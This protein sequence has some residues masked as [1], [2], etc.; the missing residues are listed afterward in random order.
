MDGGDRPRR[1]HWK[2]ER[3]PRATERLDRLPPDEQANVKAALRV[4][5]VRHGTWVVL[6]RMLKL[7][8]K[9]LERMLGRKGKPVPGLAIRLARLAGCSVE[10][11]LSGAFAR[12]AVCPTCGHTVGAQA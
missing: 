5:R 6:G 12:A 2:R 3:K 1:I 11:V 7:H 8:P 4:L 9:T 10:D